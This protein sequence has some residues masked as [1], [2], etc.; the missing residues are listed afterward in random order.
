VR[1]SR[2]GNGGA[3]E[4]VALGCLFY[5]LSGGVEVT[6]KEQHGMEWDS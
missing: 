2:N 3:D 6:A 4:L 5:E 1:S